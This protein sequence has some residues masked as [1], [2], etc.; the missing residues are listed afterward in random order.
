[1]LNSPGVWKD[2][3]IDGTGT[4]VGIIDSGV[5]FAHPALKSKWRGYDAVNDEIVDP[6]KNW[7]EA[8]P[9]YFIEQSPIPADS[10][11]SH[12]THVAGII[13]GSEED[14][15]NQIGVAPGAKYI[16]ARTFDA[17]GMTDNFVLI[18][19]GEWMLAPGGDVN[20]R[21]DVV[22]ASWASSAKVDDW[23][24]DV[25]NAWRAAGIDRKSV[26]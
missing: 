14:G 15:K 18:R 19:A 13:L 9:A 11:L 6:E 4:T 20:A 26:V 24:R 1:M 16:A 21:P 5:E 23:Y 2:F 3:E 7:F 17:R 10:S 25:V 22:N 12:G 8:I